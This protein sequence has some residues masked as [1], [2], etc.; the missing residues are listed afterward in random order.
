MDLLLFPSLVEQRPRIVVFLLALSLDGFLQCKL[1]SS[2]VFYCFGADQPQPQGLQDL[3]LDSGTTPGRNASPCS[4][5][6][7][8]R[9]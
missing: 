8:T 3:P 2:K 1:F 6:S 4:P 5:A 9:A 7:C